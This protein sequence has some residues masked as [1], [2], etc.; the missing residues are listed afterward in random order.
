[1]TTMLGKYSIN[2]L[3]A[4]LLPKRPLVSLN[5]VVAVWLFLGV[6]MFAWGQYTSH[7]TQLTN[8]ELTR[9]N[10]EKKNKTAQLADIQNLIQQRKKDPAL[11]A[12]VNTLKMVI[13]NKQALHAKLTD[14]NQTQLAGFANSMTELSK[15]H[16][17]NISLQ[18]VFI[19]QNEINLTGLAKT[20]EAVPQWLSAF[21]DSTLLSGKNFSNFKLYENENKITVFKIGSI[22]NKNTNVG[23]Q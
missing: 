2:L 6:I 4:E 21:E 19:Q 14:P 13:R 7:Q 18:E 10:I 3:Q 8:K 22:Y 17:K 5:R 1:M 12:R 9:L 11:E 16:H 15:Y 23:A 20:P